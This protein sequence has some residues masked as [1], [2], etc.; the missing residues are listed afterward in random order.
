MSVVD[1]ENDEVFDEDDL[2]DGFEEQIIDENGLVIGAD[3]ETDDDV[4]SDVLDEGLAEIAE[5][6]GEDTEGDDTVEVEDEEVLVGVAVAEPEEDE[7]EDE[8]IELALD[9]ILVKTV[10]R[11][12][13]IE[14]EDDE[15]AVPDADVL[16]DTEDAPLPRQEDEFRCS[17]CRLLKKN[18][19]LANRDRLLC[20]DCA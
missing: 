2:A 6:E 12:G 14:E 20:R 19:Q 15:V 10:R 3:D 4:L 5:L 8:D 11:S 13:A 18:S 7:T 9:E 1:D 16:L 17:S